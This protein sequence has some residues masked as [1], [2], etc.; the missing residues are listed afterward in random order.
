MSQAKSLAIVG[1]GII[2]HAHS[3]A[4][5]NH[6]GRLRLVGC[7]D[8]VAEKAS[9]FAAQYGI[10]S[11]Y[12]DF[13]EMIQKEKPDIVALSTWPILHEE[14]VLACCELRVPAI[15]C[16]KSLAMNAA[17]AQKM[18]EATESSGT[19]LLE[20]FMW[21]HHT[22]TLEA[23]RLIRQENFGPLRK[24]RAVFQRNAMA[25]APGSWKHRPET[26]G[27][28][29]YDFGCYCANAAGAFFDGL[30]ESV[31]ACWQRTPEGLVTDLNGLLL[32]PG[33]QIA[34]IESGYRHAFFQ[35][36]ELHGENSIVRITNCFTPGNQDG[37][38]STAHGK[39]RSFDPVSAAACNQADEQMLHLADCLEQGTTPRFTA[40]ESVRNH[41]ILDAMLASAEAG[42]AVKPALP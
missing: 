4:A 11:S 29:V 32:Y 35:Q 13:R 39:A 21:R 19:L 41:A 2:S 10:A 37:I 12:T 42:R 26:G 28:V 18:V 34:V 40:R 8:V 22:R 20:G 27:G 33:G 5:V 24:L 6:P 25:D 9:A 30:P 7:A 17:S 31:Q 23:Q 15:L 3:Q 16:E 1:C 14:Q 38:E 36:L